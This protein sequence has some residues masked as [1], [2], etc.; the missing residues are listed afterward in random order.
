MTSGQKT[1]TQPDKN[2]NEHDSKNK[3]LNKLAFKKLLPVLVQGCD[4]DHNENIRRH[5][6]RMFGQAVGR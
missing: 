5:R 2:G 3:A 6:R 1:Y 4:K